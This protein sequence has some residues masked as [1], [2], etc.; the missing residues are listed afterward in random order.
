MATQ[1]RCRGAPMPTA[2][3]RPS[4]LRLKVETEL[5]N[6]VDTA[7]RQRGQT[8][9]EFVRQS[10][11]AQLTA[12]GV[13]LSPTSTDDGPGPAPSAPAMRQAA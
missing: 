8:M 2:I 10:V 12:H 1:S 7:A 5:A 4:T 13:R 3:P 11:R 9:S 6:A